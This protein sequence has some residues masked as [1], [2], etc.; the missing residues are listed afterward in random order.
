MTINATT[1]TPTPVAQPVVVNDPATQADGKTNIQRIQVFVSPDELANAQRQIADF[2]AQSGV[3]SLPPP[4]I[5]TVDDAQSVSVA[6]TFEDSSEAVFDLTQLFLVLA[7]CSNTLFSTSTQRRQISGEMVEKSAM[8]AAKL[9]EQAAGKRFQ[10]AMISAGF[11]MA[12]SVV[13]M[14]GTGAGMLRS[15]QMGKLGADGK[16]IGDV[17]MTHD[18][19]AAGTQAGSGITNASGSMAAA[20]FSKQEGELEAASA[21]ANAVGAGAEKG[22]GTANDMIQQALKI[23]AA[24]QQFMQQVP[25]A[26][27]ETNKHMASNV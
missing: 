21:R 19:Y 10:A 15:G 26:D 27:I 24:M 17:R 9:K 2:Y 5:V 7:E 11:Q 4:E 22:Y 1:T 8:D 6:L 3:Q 23:F 18:E 12:G 16:P 13:T 25:Q 14:A 20:G